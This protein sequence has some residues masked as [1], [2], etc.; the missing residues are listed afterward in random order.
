[1]RALSLAMLFVLLVALTVTCIVVGDG[2]IDLALVPSLILGAAVV[3]W[4]VPLRW[5]LLVTTFLALTLENPSD[6]PACG[7]WKSPFYDVGAV[8]LVHLNVT[9]PYK[10][11]VFSGLDVVLAYLFVMAAL[12]RERFSLGGRAVENASPMA[13]FAG[14]SLA[15]A[16]W[17][18]IY[19]MAR[20]NADVPNS[21]W[22]LQR[23]AYLPA[24]V[25]LF[26]RG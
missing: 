26:Q 21:L 7:Q 15:A 16:A 4:K 5:P 25:F 1:M 24:L 19:G 8:M 2:S 18:W 3:A 13:W 22:Q 11:L 6:T 17:M 10:P 23:V 20:G 9:F 12:R 14:L